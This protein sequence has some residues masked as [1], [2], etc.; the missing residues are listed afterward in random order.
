MSRG[1]VNE[2][3]MEEIPIVQPRAHLPEGV[4]N[5]VTQVG[6]NN[7]LEEMEMLINER[8]NLNIS[9][10]SERRITTN[11]INAKLKL[12]QSRV[13]TAKT[14]DLSKQPQSKISFGALV[15]LKVGSST[16]LAH[17]Q[18]VGVDEANISEGKISFISPIAKVLLNKKVGEKATL[19]LPKGDSVFEI[20]EISYP[21]TN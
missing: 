3:D 7:L 21:S 11:H 19:K 6:M 5:Y 8:E 14:V 15:T 2:D 12:L 9:N 4:P 17:Y 13:A 10:D 1:F 18:I 16:E 20:V